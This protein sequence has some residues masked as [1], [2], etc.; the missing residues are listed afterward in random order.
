M[1]RPRREASDAPQAHAVQAE[2][3]EHGDLQ[4][5]VYLGSKRV[6]VASVPSAQV[7]AAPD[8]EG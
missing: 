4:L 2:L 7:E 3:N 6:V 5:V 1:A 8:V